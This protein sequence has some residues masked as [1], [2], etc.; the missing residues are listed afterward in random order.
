MTTQQ[1]APKT[2]LIQQNVAMI[3]DKYNPLLKYVFI[4]IIYMMYSIL[5]QWESKLWLSDKDCLP[6]PV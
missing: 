3:S 2:K 5:Y 4:V 1:T 6:F